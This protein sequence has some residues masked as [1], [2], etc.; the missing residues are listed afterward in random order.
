MNVIVHSNSFNTV[1]S[2]NLIISVDKNG[3]LESQN[4]EWLDSNTL[5][6]KSEELLTTAH[7]SQYVHGYEQSSV[8]GYEDGDGIDEEALEWSNI[9]QMQSK[10]GQTTG[11]PLDKML[12]PNALEDVVI[13]IIDDG[14]SKE[15]WYQIEDETDCVIEK[16]VDIQY[17]SYF[18]AQTPVVKTYSQIPTIANL[19]YNMRYQHGSSIA[20]LISQAANGIKLWIIDVWDS[21]ADFNTMEGF[22]KAYDWLY[23]NRDSF[24]GLDI[25]S[26]SYGDPTNYPTEKTKLDLLAG[27]DIMLFAAAGNA[28]YIDSEP[29]ITNYYPRSIESV[30][31]VGAHFDDRDNYLTDDTFFD[32]ASTRVAYQYTDDYRTSTKTWG[33]QYSTTISKTIDFMAPGFDYETLSR[34]P[35]EEIVVDGTSF[36]CP[37]ASAIAAYAV[38]T[39]ENY[40]GYTSRSS[41][42]SATYEALKK[43]S[44]VSSNS[45]QV[46]ITMSINSNYPAT[47]TKQI[48]LGYGSIDAYDTIR[49]LLKGEISSGQTSISYGDHYNNPVYCKSSKEVDIFQPGDYMLRAHYQINSGGWNTI[50]FAHTFTTSGSHTIEEWIA[51]TSPL[52][53]VEIYWELVDA[54]SYKTLNVEE[55]T[56]TYRIPPVEI[57]EGSCCVDADGDPGGPVIAH[58]AFEVFIYGYYYV[59]VEYRVDSGSGWGTTS[60]ISHNGNRNPGTYVFNDNIGNVVAGYRYQ[61]TWT[62]TYAPTSYD[63][64]HVITVTANP[65]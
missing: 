17:N 34:D 32:D 39:C 36:A 50:G 63:T 51:S 14:L 28:A 46:S 23:T 43:A 57:L 27:D 56:T 3:N 53:L 15:M 7:S 9:D 55:S 8:I 1:S 65:S 38:A 12:N 19:N 4:I 48:K 59:K 35:T 22:Y 2:S 41:I 16:Y 58:L 25:I 31:G 29:E 64:D 52:D 60:T 45:D 61:V 10:W 21:D 13:A 24:S 44:E 47:P 54:N 11:D 6:L 42:K 5:N 49:Y 37:H 20:W 62:I 30:W 33:S 40:L 18:E 26:M